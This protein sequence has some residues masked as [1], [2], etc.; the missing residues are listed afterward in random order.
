MGSKS[1]ELRYLVEVG[2]YHDIVDSHKCSSLK[3]A[4]EWLSK[5]G[6]IKSWG[7]GNCYFEVSKDG[8]EVGFNTLHENKF[9][10]EEEE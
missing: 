2:V 10:N 1:K 6:W 9:Y 3:E 7:R 4:R 8:R 5:E